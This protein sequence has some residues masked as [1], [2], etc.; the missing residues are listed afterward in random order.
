MSGVLSAHFDSAIAFI[1]RSNIHSY[2]AQVRKNN[3]AVIDEFEFDGRLFL[4]GDVS[5][6]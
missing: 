6:T 2:H 5:L 4:D 3:M 1:A